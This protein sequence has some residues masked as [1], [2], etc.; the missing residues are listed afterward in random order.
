MKVLIVM[1]LVYLRWVSTMDE[2]DESRKKST[3]IF[4]IVLIIMII[5]MFKIGP[6]LINLIQNS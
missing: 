5:V 3:V 2:D 6:S 1:L 4:R